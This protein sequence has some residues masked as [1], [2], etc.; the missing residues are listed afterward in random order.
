MTAII[1]AALLEQEVSSFT[2]A[3]KRPT[4]KTR[5]Q[6]IF[7]ERP[8]HRGYF[9]IAHVVNCPEQLRIAVIARPIDP[10]GHRPHSQH[11]VGREPKCWS[12]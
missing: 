6:S 12:M 8:I 11:V 7:F 1:V 9:G 5:Q 3:Y 10:P 2:H 4:D